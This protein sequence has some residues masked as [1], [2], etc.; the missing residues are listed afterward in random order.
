M[1]RFVCTIML[2]TA[3]L[4]TGCAGPQYNWWGNYS[5]SLYALKKDP[6]KEN[7]ENH[8]QTLLAIMSEADAHGRTPP[9]GVCCE[10]G[11]LLYK[12]GKTEESMKYFEREQKTYPESAVFIERL[13]SNLKT[14]S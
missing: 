8:K 13:K 9:P 7:L 2:V 3:L 6:T 11:F 1:R 14:R 5:D 12:E 10:Y 4:I